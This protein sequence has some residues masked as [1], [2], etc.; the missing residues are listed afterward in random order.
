VVKRYGSPTFREAAERWAEC[1]AEFQLLVNAAHERASE[2][3]RGSLLN[4]AGKAKRI[5]AVTLFYGPRN[6]AMCYASEELIDWWE[7]NPRITFEQYER[8]A[9]AQWAA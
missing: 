9:G 7:R 5:D 1:R 2:E 3:C 4:R 6:R 8:E